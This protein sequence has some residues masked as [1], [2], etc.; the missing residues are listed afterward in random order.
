MS[1][2]LEKVGDLF[3]PVLGPG[4]NIQKALTRLSTGVSLETPEIPFSGDALIA[5]PGGSTWKPAVLDAGID[6]RAALAYMGDPK[7]I[8]FL[9]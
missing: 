5:G 8:E 7:P 3:K 6:Y 9:G 1:K 2:R 4:M